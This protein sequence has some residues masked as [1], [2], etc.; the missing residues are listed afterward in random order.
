MSLARPK[1]TRRS[2]R[3]PLRR[4]GGLVFEERLLVLG[5]VVPDGG[6]VAVER[7]VEVG[8]CKARR[9][10]GEAKGESG[11]RGSVCV[12]DGR[13][14]PLGMPRR[15][16]SD[17]ARG[18]QARREVA[19]RWAGSEAASGKRAGRKRIGA[20]ERARTAEQA[21]DRQQDRADVV[22]GRPL[23]L[24]RAEEGGRRLAKQLGWGCMLNGLCGMKARA[25]RMR[26]PRAAQAKERAG[27]GG[28][29][30]CR[31]A[32]SAWGAP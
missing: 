11:T 8:V 30:Y 25:R 10:W 13:V 2:A 4:V 31:R 24:Q 26:V 17:A 22:H 6:S 12:R 9:G 28:V 19:A 1:R 18:S 3:S 7:A 20:V 15:S 23:L 5:H 14:W 27:G 29:R 16:A 32:P 21:L